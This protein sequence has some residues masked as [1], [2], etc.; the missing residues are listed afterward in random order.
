[1]PASDPKP[2]S[3]SELEPLCAALASV[4]RDRRERAGWS[5]NGLATRASL[6]HPMIRFVENSERIPTIDTLAR[7]SRAL[8]V[9]CSRLMAEAERRL[10]L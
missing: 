6:S 4:I 1:M 8:D 7:I 9:P 3:R 2:V 5:L 10:K